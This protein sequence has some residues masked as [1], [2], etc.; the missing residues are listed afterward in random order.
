MLAKFH[1]AEDAFALHLP[2]QRLERLV[3]I[4]VS[5]KTCTRLSFLR[6]R[7]VADIPEE[8]QR[9]IF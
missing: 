5:T 2:L 1:L 3:D 6:T 9:A 8:V 4:V 7:H